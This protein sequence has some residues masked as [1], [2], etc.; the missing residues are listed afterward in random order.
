MGNRDGR[1][2]PAHLTS[3]G[4]ALLAEL[5]ESELRALYAQAPDVDLPRLSRQLRLVRR[6]G[7]AIN[8]Q[9]TE[10]GV[11]A[12]GRA[13]HGPDGK[14]VAA[15][16]LSTPSTRFHST[17]LTAWLEALARTTTAI[18]A[19]LSATVRPSGS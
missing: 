8:N 9:Q 1:I 18:G 4:K 2:L 12:V 19:E 13:V 7:F 3:G 6:R 17:R 15:V 5:S 10:R 14:A 16:T 11:T